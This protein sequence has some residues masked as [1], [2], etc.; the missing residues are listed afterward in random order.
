MMKAMSE[1]LAPRTYCPPATLNAD[2]IKRIYVRWLAEHPEGMH[3]PAGALLYEAL[4]HHFACGRRG[5]RSGRG[6]SM[7]RTMAIDPWAP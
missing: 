2:Q 3:R 6:N 5:S 7:R 1:I 4:M